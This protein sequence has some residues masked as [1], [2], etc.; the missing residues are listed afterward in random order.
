MTD[1]RRRM[2]SAAKARRNAAA[3]GDVET[4]SEE[5]ETE[6]VWMMLIKARSNGVCTSAGVYRAFKTRSV[7]QCH[8]NKKVYPAVHH[9]APRKNCQCFDCSEHFVNLVPASASTLTSLALT[10]TL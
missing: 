5:L 8:A 9:E 4:R 3:E 2:A 10:S 1:S 6:V 7:T